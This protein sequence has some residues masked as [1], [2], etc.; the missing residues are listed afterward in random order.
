MMEKMK[1][2]V[3]LLF[4]LALVVP[5]SSCGLLDF[6]VDDELADIAADMALDADTVYVM[7]GD[8]MTLKPV[9][10]PDT[11]NIKDVLISSSD[12]DVVSVNALTGRI[13]AVGQGWAWLYVE[14]VSARLKDSCAV[15]VMEPWE[16]SGYY[17]FETVFYATVTVGGKPL[18]KDM[19][20][21]AFVGSECR[22]LAMPQSFHGV[23]FTLFRVGSEEWPY[24]MNPMIPDNPDIPLEEE[25]D[26]DGQGGG[27]EVV[28]E[29]IE[30]RC[31]DSLHRKLYT[32]PRR[33]D[34]DGE[35]YG[36][37]SNLYK[38]EF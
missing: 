33:I 2:G 28:R 31:Y 35:T 7:R 6:D 8:T 15:C 16:V 19:T 26:D 21:A 22:A 1:R 20:V 5:V 29:Q 27:L 9:F 18:S 36:T 17:P 3:R 4:Y 38:I 14:S 37:L 11:V 24:E 25:E 12:N 23:A 34:F 13:E 10:K 32:C 30:F